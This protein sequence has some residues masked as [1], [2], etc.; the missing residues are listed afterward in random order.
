[1]ARRELVSA[2]LALGACA[3]VVALQTRQARR[4]NPPIGR[5][6]QVNGVR[7]H[8]VERGS[9]PA[10]VL[11]HGNGS[12]VQDFLTSD[13]VRLAAQTHRVIIFDRPGYGWSERPRSHLWTPAAQADLLAAA[14][15]RLG[16]VRPHLLGH[17]WG[18]LVAIE[19]AL[20]HR[21]DVAA[22]T[23]VSGYYFATPRADVV[24]A[25]GP[26]VP[27]VGD[28][29][30]F[31]ALPLVGQLLWPRILRKL[32]APSAVPAHFDAVPRGLILSPLSLR[33][34]AEESAFMLPTAA[35]LQARYAELTLP[36]AIVAGGGDRIVDPSRQS[37]RLHRAISGS[38]LSIL[39]GVGHMLHHSEPRVLAEIS[40]G[41]EPR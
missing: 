40:R 34:S 24:L 39:P 41:I 30:R 20:N 21:D 32:F 10:L 3:T 38:R 11:L 23:L 15:K 37:E 29:L 27:V 35:K 5:F 19:W 18:S 25:S 16:A 4:H 14:A 22:L 28:V 36:V 13:F 17:S 33:A 1:M 8:Y 6:I 2:G 9:G 12:L 26:A 31:T 7:L